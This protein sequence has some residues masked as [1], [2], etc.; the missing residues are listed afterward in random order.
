MLVDALKWIMAIIFIESIT[1]IVVS[2][3]LFVSIRNWIAKISKFGGSLI[4]CGY[5]MS[6]WM[7]ISIAWALPGNV[8]P[9]DHAG[10]LIFN[11]VIKIF[12]LHRLSNIFHEAVS[13]WMNRY[14]WVLSI[15]NTTGVDN[16]DI[17]DVPEEDDG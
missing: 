5:C 12:I 4:S 13:R 9:G 8:I 10:F 7:S 2:S 14:P 6:V 17:V 16:D 11:I 3:D 1:E 15:S